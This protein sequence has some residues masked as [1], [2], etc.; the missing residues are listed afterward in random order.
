MTTDADLMVTK[1]VY[2][3]S[4]GLLAG[5]VFTTVVMILLFAYHRRK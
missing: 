1:H 2:I 3:F 4:N 5:I